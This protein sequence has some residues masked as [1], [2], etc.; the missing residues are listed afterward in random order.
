MRVR[1]LLH[2]LTGVWCVGICAWRIARF[3]GKRLLLEVGCCDRSERVY[4]LLVFLL[5]RIKLRNLSG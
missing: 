4:C 1:A 3:V 2:A 5:A